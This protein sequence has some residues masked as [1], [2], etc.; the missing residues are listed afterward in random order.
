MPR[1]IRHLEPELVRGR[2]SWEARWYDP[3]RRGGRSLSMGTDDPR[4]AAARF[5]AWLVERAAASGQ[6]RPDAPEVLTVEG[7]I[8]AYMEEHVAA[9]GSR[10]ADPERARYCAAMLSRGLGTSRVSDLSIP[11]V[12][13]YRQRRTAGDLRNAHGAN[14]SDETVRRELS[15]LTAA[16]NHAVRWKRLPPT[17]V[18]YIELPPKS[19]PRMRWLTK[20]ELAALW[21]CAGPRA[22]LFARI[23]YYTAARRRAVETLQVDQV[24]LGRHLIYFGSS[25]TKK[26]RGA[27][28]LYEPIAVEVAEACRLHGPAG[29]VLEHDGAIRTAFENAARRAGLGPDVTPHVLRHSRATHM[30]QDGE[31]IWKVAGLLH[32]TVETIERVYGHHCPEYLREGAGK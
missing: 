6:P 14:A 29:F 3:E 5:Q 19:E 1:P 23:A 11:V 22:R 15:L 16:L 21:R 20:D 30:L 27:V 17:G 25:G 4:E 26:R 32:D 31:P 2:V 7:V 18:P 13:Q 8:R 12:R 24:D 28:P 9:D 10:V